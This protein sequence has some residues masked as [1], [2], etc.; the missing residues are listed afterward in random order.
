MLRTIIVL[1]IFFS[2]LITAQELYEKPKSFTLISEVVAQEYDFIEHQL[3]SEKSILYA[4]IVFE[5]IKQFDI[6]GISYTVV[7]TIEQLS[8]RGEGKKINSKYS[9]TSLL[10]YYAIE[11]NALEGNK[12]N[13]TSKGWDIK[14]G[15][16]V[17]PFKVYAFQTGDDPLDFSPSNVSMGPSLGWA[18]QI[19]RRK[20]DVW[21]TYKFSMNITSVT[22]RPD[23]FTDSKLQGNDLVA[24][25]PALGISL[26][27][28]TAEVNLYLGKDYLPGNAARAWKYNGTTWFSLAIGLSI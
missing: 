4:D 5:E 2:N 6:E 25:S 28:N 7:K 21:L 16:A 19:S 8:K 13:Y 24:L 10:E 23:E 12:L 11:T 22:P 27:Y 17:I 26:N 18:H 9:E 1:L 15:F 14:I 3:L 20:S